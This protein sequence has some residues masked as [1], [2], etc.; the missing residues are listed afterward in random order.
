MAYGVLQAGAA[1]RAMESYLACIRS[2]MDAALCLRNFAS[3][4]VERH[5]K[6]EVE[7]RYSPPPSRSRVTRAARSGGKD[8]T[9]QGEDGVGNLVLPPIVIH[10]GSADKASEPTV[11]SLLSGCADLYRSERQRCEGEYRGPAE[12]RRREDDREE[13]YA[14]HDASSR[15]LPGSRDPTPSHTNLWCISTGSPQASNAGEPEV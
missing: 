4:K 1:D 12:G 8:I 14:V 3:E 2:T 13:V 6:P 7:C 15:G 9:T 11:A 10:K 5:N